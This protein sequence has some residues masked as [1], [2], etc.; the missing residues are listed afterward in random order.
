[1]IFGS[2]LTAIRKDHKISQGELAQRPAIHS[3][4]L[5]RYEREEATPCVEMG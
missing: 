1:M 5:G 3:N 4:L 2:R